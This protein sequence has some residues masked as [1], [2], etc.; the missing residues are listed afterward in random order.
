[1]ELMSIVGSLNRAWRVAAI[2]LSLGLSAEAQVTVAPMTSVRVTTSNGS[3]SVRIVSADSAT[4]VVENIAGERHTVARADITAIARRGGHARQDAM[5]LGGIGLGIGA[6]L[7]ALLV[8]G[9]CETSNCSDDLPFGM[10]YVGGFF[11]AVGAITGATLGHF[12]GGWRPVDHDVRVRASSPVG[13]CISHP[14]FE[15]QFTR[16]PQTESKR[17]RFSVGAVCGSGTVFGVEYAKLGTLAKEQAMEVADPQFG[18]VVTRN[19]MTTE[20]SFRGAFAEHPLTT[21]RLRLSAIAAYGQYTTDSSLFVSSSLK[22]NDANVDYPAFF[23]AY[24]FE[25]VRNTMH[26]F[27][28]SVGAKAAVALGT[29]FSAGLTVR[30]DRAG[31]RSQGIESGI[32]ISV[33]P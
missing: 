12:T 19:N 26:R 5:V 16:S 25:S 27:G 29:Q 9:L 3:E 4:L 13:V 1:M 24:P 23:Q 7:G 6:A 10:L 31:S 14:R 33:R 15:G 8:E 2:S 17:R 21:G 20:T 30:L 32:G 11:G 18:H 22:D 28:F